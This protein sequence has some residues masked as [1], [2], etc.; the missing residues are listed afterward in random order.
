M[1]VANL[2]KSAAQR[3]GLG[4][5]FN[6][7]RACGGQRITPSSLERRESSPVLGCRMP[8]EGPPRCFPGHPRAGQHFNRLH[9][10][11][12]RLG[13]EVALGPSPASGLVSS[14]AWSFTHR[15]FSCLRKCKTTRCRVAVRF[16]TCIIWAFLSSCPSPQP[17]L[18]CSQ[19]TATAG[20]YLREAVPPAAAG[21][22]TFQGTL[23]P[24]GRAIR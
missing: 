1:G 22:C 15:P 5:P 11:F 12:S 17:G 23:T 4:F 21:G 16:P 13:R 7:P 10:S 20:M 2:R 6:S 19:A 9:H 8:L 18:Q 24:K 14:V 3:S